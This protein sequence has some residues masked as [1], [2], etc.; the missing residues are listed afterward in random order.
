VDASVTDQSQRKIQVVWKRSGIG[1]TRRQRASVRGLGLRRLNQVVER[2]DTPQTRGL[3]A[4][5]PHLVEY[6]TAPPKP[7]PWAAVPEYTVIPRP[8]A[9]KEEA[10]A[11]R[12]VSEAAPADVTPEKPAEPPVK[13]AK[14]AKPAKATVEKAKAPAEKKA[15]AAVKSAKSKTAKGK[16]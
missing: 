6:V 2:E 16:K 5:V 13:R 4:A 7:S 14:A 1:F 15:K 12:I 9:T 10:A 8:A 3:V 11:A